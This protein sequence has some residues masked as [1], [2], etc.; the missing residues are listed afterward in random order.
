MPAVSGLAALNAGREEGCPEQGS[1]V[2]HGTL[3]G[4]I[5]DVH[6]AELAS[7]MEMDRPFDGLVEHTKRVSPTCLVHFERHRSSVPA[8]FA[9]RPVSL[10]VYPDRIVIAAEGQVL[11]EHRL[12]ITR[13]HHLRGPPVYDRRHYLAVIQRK[14]GALRNGAPFT[15][16]PDAFRQLQAHLLRHP[17]GDREMVDILS[18]VLHHDEQAV[19][20][21]VELALEAGVPK[22]GRASWRERVGEYEE[23]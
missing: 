5:A 13:A 18:L 22:I 23:I 10:L 15:E 14:P 6:A 21:A 16:M 19:L 20:C 11:S 1:Q 12:I 3:P 4:T 17:G 7:L 2:P 9:N 8:S